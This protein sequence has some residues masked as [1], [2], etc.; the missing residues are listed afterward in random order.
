MNTKFYSL[1]FE[2][3]FFCDLFFDIQNNANFQLLNFFQASVDEIER[4]EPPHPRQ[5]LSPPA[6]VEVPKS[7]HRP[8]QRTQSSPAASLI[9]K[10]PP[11]K[12]SN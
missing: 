7:I 8:L 9:K 4:R 3:L 1:W 11:S 12:V 6:K 5:T 2:L 10:L